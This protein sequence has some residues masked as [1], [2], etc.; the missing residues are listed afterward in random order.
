M[1]GN[2][3]LVKSAS[4]IDSHIIIFFHFINKKIILVIGKSCVSDVSVAMNMRFSKFICDNWF[5]SRVLTSFIFEKNLSTHAVLRRKIDIR[6]SSFKQLGKIMAKALSFKH[7]DYYLCASKEVSEARKGSLSF[8][9]LQFIS[10]IWNFPSLA[11]LFSNIYLRKPA[12]SS[13]AATPSISPTWVIVA[14]L[15][16]L[17]F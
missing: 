5:Q 10:F 16:V 2:Q 17:A 1:S 14:D 7:D 4:N 13:I 8:S 12:Q 11:L 6:W 15:Y 3:I 9:F